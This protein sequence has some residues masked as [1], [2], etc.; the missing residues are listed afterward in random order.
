MNV[1][2]KKN[3]KTKSREMNKEYV[4][5]LYNGILLSY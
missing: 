5:H 3:I 1:K 4:V 2:K